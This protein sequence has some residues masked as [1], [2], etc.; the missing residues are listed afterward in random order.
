MRRGPRKSGGGMTSGAAA[1]PASTA[2]GPA[3]VLAQTRLQLTQAREAAAPRRMHP[4]FGVQGAEGGG[5]DET[6]SAHGPEDGREG[7]RSHARGPRRTSS[8]RSRR[9]YRPNWTC[10]SSYREP[11]CRYRRNHSVKI[12]KKIKNH[13]L[14]TFFKQLFKM[15]FNFFI[16]A[17]FKIIFENLS[18]KFV[19]YFGVGAVGWGLSGWGAVRVRMVRL[20]GSVGPEGWEPRRVGAPKGGGPE[21]CGAKKGGR[22]PKPE[23]SGGPEGWGAQNFAFFFPSPATIF[24]L[25]DSLWGLLVELLVFEAP[26]PSNV[27]V[28]CSP[29][30]V[31]RWGFRGGGFPRRGVARRMV[32]E[33]G[34]LGAPLNKRNHHTVTS[35]KWLEQPNL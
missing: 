14:K 18:L 7:A 30:V 22:G 12:H 2:K 10:T 24:A 23:K 9:L 17:N 35:E 32:W 16:L 28:W 15:H 6:S 34:G 13:F 4:H 11:H 20:P 27:N 21:G 31:Q 26:G 5:R 8:K 19:N 29:A 1:R 33:K 25:F 3:Q